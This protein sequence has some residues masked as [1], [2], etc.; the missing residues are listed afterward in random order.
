M[1]KRNKQLAALRR[2]QQRILD[3]A[4]R[5][6]LRGVPVARHRPRLEREAMQHMNSI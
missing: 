2:E 3:T 4:R 1:S 5:E 6:A